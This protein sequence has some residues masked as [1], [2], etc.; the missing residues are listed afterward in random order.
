VAIRTS[1]LLSVFAIAAAVGLA[2]FGFM[3]W[4]SISVERIEP[5]EALRRFQAIRS[6][7]SGAEPILR[8]QPDGHVV[9]SK[10]PLGE[11]QPPKQFRVL[12]YRAP[13]R[14]LV[15]AKIA[16]WFLKAKGPAVIYSLRG[17]G[18]DLDRLGISPAELARYGPRLVFDETGADGGR[19]L[20][21]TE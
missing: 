21:W 19:L 15:Q 20:V 13:E 4:R 7:F 14:Q 11:G 5:D 6:Q 3:A 16:F 10:E 9:R 8:V 18:L 17:T 12:A 1:R 2:L